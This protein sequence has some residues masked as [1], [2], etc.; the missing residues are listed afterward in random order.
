M[1][2]V[3]IETAKLAR[4]LD[5]AENTQYASDS[6][7]ETHFAFDLIGEPEFTAEDI[8]NAEVNSQIDHYLIPYQSQLHDWLVKNHNIV[9]SYDCKFQTVKANNTIKMIPMFWYKLY[10]SPTVDRTELIENKQQQFNSIEGAMEA[11]LLKALNLIKK[12]K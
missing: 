4:K 10:H 8:T 6:F 9:V 3:S 12:V 5:F 2:R 1:H 11:G 7:G